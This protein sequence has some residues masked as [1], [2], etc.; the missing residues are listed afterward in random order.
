MTSPP[1]PLLLAL[2]LL[3]AGC[4]TTTRTKRYYDGGCI[5]QGAGGA[6]ETVD[7]V[8]IWSEG[9][10]PRNYRIL[11]MV[12]D[13]RGAG[14]IPQATFHS[15][16]AKAVKRE[17]GDAAII[18]RENSR[19]TGSLSLANA[20]TTATNWAARTN[21]W[22]TAAGA[23]IAVL[24]KQTT[25]AVIKYTGTAAAPRETRV[26]IPFDPEPFAP[27]TTPGRARLF[28]RAAGRLRG[29]LVELI[30]HAGYMKTRD[31]AI[32]AGKD[33]GPRDPR[34]VRFVRQSVL[35]GEGHYHFDAL[36]PGDYLV[37]CRF[38]ARPDAPLEDDIETARVI[39]LAADE[40]RQ[41]VLTPY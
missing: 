2:A 6:M 1:A 35:D 36:P 38:Q 37:L 10:P 14:W 32:A 30:P 33:P 20:Q 18:L 8:E 13:E 17:H 34:L 41:L 7:G 11:A 4:A 16:I 28:G 5:H 27:Y 40:N 39:T 21:A 23:T 3:L 31:E 19:Q 15:T 29:G 24:R 22:T 12:E 25:I 9:A 26:D